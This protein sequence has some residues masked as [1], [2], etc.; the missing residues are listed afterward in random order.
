MDG[1]IFSDALKDFDFLVRVFSL[2]TITRQGVTFNLFLIGLK[3]RWNFLNGDDE[4][5]IRHEGM[6]LGLAFDYMNFDINLEQNLFDNFETD[7][8]GTKKTYLIKPK[9]TSVVLDGKLI[10][11]TPELTTNVSTFWGF[12]NTYAGVGLVLTS[13]KWDLKPK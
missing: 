12:I 2:P 4:G 10:T 8:T 5:F 11:I 13:E 1:G 7:P 9:K 6:S 3:P